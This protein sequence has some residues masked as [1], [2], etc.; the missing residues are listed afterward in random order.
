MVD[1]WKLIK[2]VKHLAAKLCTTLNASRDSN[3]V[4][5]LGMLIVIESLQSIFRL[6]GKTSNSKPNPIY[7]NST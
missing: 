5:L 4:V 6:L 7:V 3:Q 1:P 2:F